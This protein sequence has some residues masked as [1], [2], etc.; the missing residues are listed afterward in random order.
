MSAPVAFEIVVGFAMF[1]LV[2]VPLE[3]WFAL[4]LRQP[5]FRPGWLTDVT[6]YIAGCFVGKF[7]DGLSLSAMLLMRQITGVDTG[8]AVAAQPAW[9][10][11]IEVLLVSDFIA[12]WYH[13][14]IHR[15]S[16]LWRFHKV[17]HCS[18]RLDWLANVRL[19]PLDKIA[20]DCAQFVPIFFLGF[21]AAPLVAYTIVLG[22]QGFLNHSNVK[23]SFGP[24]RWVVASPAFHH[25]HHCNDSETYNK[26]FAPHL[27]IF[28]LLFGTFFLPADRSMPVRYGL[29]EAAPATF[30]RQIIYPFEHSQ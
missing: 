6:Y 17:H 10:Q 30:W 7:S 9:L 23:I 4:Y 29:R 27:V 2:F 3:R 5:V 26:N 8:A 15:F 21:S 22:F 20:G 13:R 25:W 24:L 16:W 11:F 18:P 12:Y 14:L 28:D 19:H 1:A